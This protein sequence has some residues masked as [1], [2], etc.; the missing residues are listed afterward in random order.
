MVI[1]KRVAIT[2]DI[3]LKDRGKLFILVFL[4]VGFLK[5]IV[6]IP[7]FIVYFFWALTSL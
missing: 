2:G 5:L 7:H 1:I 6:S 3:A 4:K